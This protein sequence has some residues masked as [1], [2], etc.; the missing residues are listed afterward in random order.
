MQTLLQSIAMLV[1]NRYRLKQ[2]P[3]LPL[4]VLAPESRWLQG[5]LKNCQLVA[6]DARDWG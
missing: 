5:D 6:A 4:R 2:N 3:A 1:L